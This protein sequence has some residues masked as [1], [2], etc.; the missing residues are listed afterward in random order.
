MDPQATG[1]SR[2]AEKRLRAI[3]NLGIMA[4]IDAGKTTVTERLLFVAGRT[5]KMGE[6]HAGR[7]GD[8]LDGA[9]ARAG[10]HHHLGGHHASPGAAT[11]ST[12]ST[13]RA[14]STSPSRWS[15]RC[16]CST[17]RW[18]SSTR[19]RGSSR[20]ARRSGTRPTAGGCR[21]SPSP[22]RWT[23]WAPTSPPR[24]PRCAGASPARP[25]PRS[26]G[27]SGA[28]AAFE[29]L[30][31]PGGGR[32]GPLPR[33]GRPAGLRRRAGA[34]GRRARRTGAPCWRRWPTTT[35]RRPRR[36]STTGCSTRPGCG[37][38]SGAPP[39][40][41]AS[42]R[43][44][45]AR[46]STT[47]GSRSSSTRSATGSPPRSR[48]RR[49]PGPP[50]T[51]RRRRPARWTRPAP[52]LALA[53][54]VSLLDEQRRFVFLRLYAG[55]LAEGDEVWNAS[56]GKAERVS[57]LLQMH[58]AQKTR[59]PQ[60]AAGQIVAVMGLKE[61]RTGDTLTDRAH[62][63]LLERLDAYAPVV[64]QSI[65][66]GTQA[67][68][69]PLHQALAR[70]ADE[71]PTFAFGED[72]ETGQLLVSGMGELHLEIVAERLRR[73]FRLAVRTGQPQVVLRETLSAAGRGGGHLR[74]A[75][76]RRAALRP[77]GGAGGAR[78]PAAR[79]TAS[80]WR[81]RS[82]RRARCATGCSTSP[83][84]GRAR[85]PR[86]ACW[87][88]TRSRT[89]RSRSLA[90]EWRD[91]ASKPFAF[92]VATAGAVREAAARAGPVLLEPVARLEVVTPADHL[93]DVIASLDRRGG[94]VLDVTERG[95]GGADGGRRGAAA[96]ALRL[97][98]RPALAHPGAGHL[99]DAPRPV[100]C[101]LALR[102]PLAPR[103]GPRSGFFSGV[104]PVR[105]DHRRSGMGPGAARPA[106]RILLGGGA[107]TAL[108]AGRGRSAPCL[109]AAARRPDDL[110]EPGVERRVGGQHAPGL[111]RPARRRRGRSPGRRPAATRSSPA[112]MSQGFSLASQ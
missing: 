112:A 83:A 19:C 71:D 10:H 74:A 41:A 90:A 44:C 91:G 107:P 32:H 77:G 33:R 21:A 45:A 66:A 81:R 29:R 93:G 7:G 97:R 69:E 58:A 111:E 92:K 84:R 11:S 39:W 13:P 82:R 42:C 101:G 53:F 1:L 34:L 89:W 103:S 95:A 65:E 22:T 12:S 99:H 14:T 96:A 48:W 87:R 36:S 70:I 94:L 76:R 68:R 61:T 98:H 80:W 59:L 106:E 6:V 8:G 23:G 31:G 4:H 104:G 51:A 26:S 5:H 75:A 17:A 43:S 40:P 56:L 88:A 49:P 54:K 79:A 15:A 109:I 105:P 46:R 20:R 9:R 35:T 30:R 18:R 16:G 47:R 28:E 60:A 73:E 27:R 52:L 24:W 3:R 57:R 72:Q 63:R 110:E 37:R 85:R 2:A 86:P 78:W 64:S 67:E 38:P 25:S 62:P 108:P 55:R 102:R 100:R 50:R